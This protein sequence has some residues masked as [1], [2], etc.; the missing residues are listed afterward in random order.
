M[1]YDNREVMVDGVRCR[2]DSYW[3]FTEGGKQELVCR[4]YSCGDSWNEDKKKLEKS[5]PVPKPAL[6]PAEEGAIDTLVTV[7][8]FDDEQ[9]K[10]VRELAEQQKWRKVAFEILEE[11]AAK[12]KDTEK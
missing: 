9:R 3:Q 8:G 7:F 2:W 1:K 11:L 5:V 6:S 12:D 10:L 4:R